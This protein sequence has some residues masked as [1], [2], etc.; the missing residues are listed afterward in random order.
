MDTPDPYTLV[1]HFKDPYP[2]FFMDLS[3]VVGATCQ[4]VVCKKYIETV[5]E[6]VAS[7][8]PIGSGPYKLVENK[9]GSYFKFEALDSHWR[10]VPEFKTITLRLMSGGKHYCSCAQ[11]QGDRRGGEYSR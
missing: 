2:T 6:D 7:Q 10:V 11:E 4:G 5:G 1:V 3:L 8:K 9:S